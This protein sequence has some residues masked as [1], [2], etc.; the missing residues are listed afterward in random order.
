MGIRI[1]IVDDEEI[2]RDN[3]ARFFTRKGHEVIEASSGNKA[4]DV[5]KSEPFDL[6]ISDMR[7]A[8]GDGHYLYHHSR[9]VADAPKFIFLTGFSE[10]A[11]EELAKLPDVVSVETKPVEK[12]VLLETILNYFA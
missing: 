8:D 1:L 9:K 2:L 11:E 6:I 4:L 12:K 5:L 3:L 10:L 7:M